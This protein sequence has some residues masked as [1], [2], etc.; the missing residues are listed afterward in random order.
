MRSVDASRLVR[1]DM[2]RTVEILD[3]AARDIGDNFLQYLFGMT[4]I[5]LDEKVGNRQPFDDAQPPTDPQIA[6]AARMVSRGEE[7]DT[8]ER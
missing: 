5:Y 7:D 4:I 8:G 6:R 2:R 1:M 3:S